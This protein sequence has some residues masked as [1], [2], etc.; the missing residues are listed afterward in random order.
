MNQLSSRQLRVFCMALSALIVLGAS[1]CRS[2]LF[3]ERI[4]SPPAGTDTD[5]TVRIFV[6]RNGD[7]Y[8]SAQVPLGNPDVRNGIQYYFTSAK[9]RQRCVA[10]S[11]SPQ[12]ELQSL[13]E[14]NALI[15]PTKDTAWLALQGRMW[16]AHAR[17]I[18]ARALQPN[19]QK[20]PVVIF[21]HGY[22]NKIPDIDQ[23]YAALRG[24]ILR[25]PA[26]GGRTPVVVEVFWDGRATA[27]PIGVY[28]LAQPT[29]SVV[30]FNLRQLL[31]ALSQHVDADTPV[32][33]LA[34]SSGG[35]ISAALVGNTTHVFSDIYPAGCVVPGQSINFR[36]Y[37]EDPAGSD[38]ASPVR[39]PQLKDLRIGLL[40][41]ATPS[42]SFTGTLRPDGAAPNGVQTNSLGL[43]LSSNPRDPALGM[44]CRFG[45]FGGSSCLGR[46]G[47]YAVKVQQHFEARSREKGADLK[48]TVIDFPGQRTHKFGA[49]L[50]NPSFERFLEASLDFSADSGST[51]G[52]A[53][54]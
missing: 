18:A 1:G 14:Y 5:S 42:Q 28:S 26:L 39:I 19:G 3:A 24:K 35:I 53:A 33:I 37:C 17:D 25:A 54:E 47:Q 6:D 51:R 7:L 40:A 49:Y 2:V 13:C 45:N 29:A 27:L 32:R 23:N 12:T 16:E 21:L 44:S 10:S 34:H 43:V 48:V 50:E 9:F 46:G 30:G 4:K 8:P 22:R 41:A 31:N 52:T 20:R 15:G 38:P 11:A 36:R